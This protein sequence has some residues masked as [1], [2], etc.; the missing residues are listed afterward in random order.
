[1]VKKLIFSCFIQS[2]NIGYQTFVDLLDNLVPATLDIYTNLFRGN[3]FEEY[4]ET[5]FRLWTVML[6]SQRKNYNKL[7][8]AF[9]SDIQYWHNCQHP[10]INL[11]KTELQILDEYPVENF[12][13]LVRCYTS[14]KVN[15]PD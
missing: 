7:M 5:I 11:L 14:S 9:I 1:M 2:K 10:I 6:R 3:R 4:L 12:Y 8:L 13:S 15:T